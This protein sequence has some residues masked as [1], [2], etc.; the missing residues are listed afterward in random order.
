MR[1]APTGIEADPTWQAALEIAH[2]AWA[3]AE[4]AFDAKKRENFAVYNSKGHAA[5]EAF[6]RAIEMTAQWELD[7]IDEHGDADTPVRKIMR[8]RSEWFEQTRLLRKTKSG[9]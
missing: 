4:E 1:S 2:D 7:L 5:K 6:D 9:D 3:L 8:K